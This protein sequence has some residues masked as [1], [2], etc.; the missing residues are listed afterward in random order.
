M[1]NSYN[2]NIL[3]LK[4]SN[5]IFSQR[6]F[7]KK[8]KLIHDHAI[9]AFSDGACRG[10]PGPA[11]SAALIF[12]KLQNFHYLIKQSL[13]YQTNNKAELFALWLIL[14]LIYQN[15]HFFHC[16]KKEVHIFTDSDY[17]ISL[18][19][20]RRD[21]RSNQQLFAWIF[22]EF[23]FF[24]HHG[25]FFKFYYVKGHVKIQLNEKVD[26]QAVLASFDPICYPYNL[27]KRP[28]IP[29]RDLL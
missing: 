3:S 27:N 28:K 25:W 14:K 4:E 12:N 11:G 8:L 5:L 16:L 7:E 19:N 29:A 22:N 10:N 23:S 18:F 21:P 17:C 24:R 20:N 9:V 2:G 26:E 1:H 6:M 13:G 15:C